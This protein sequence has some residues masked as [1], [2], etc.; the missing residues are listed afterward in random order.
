M[1]SAF[2]ITMVQFR[3]LRERWTGS[4]TA[5]SFSYSQGYND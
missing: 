5:A 3:F 2:C 4:M 1:H